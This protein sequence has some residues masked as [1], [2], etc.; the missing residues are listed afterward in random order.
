MKRDAH[1]STQGIVTPLS[2]TASMIPAQPARLGRQK[3]AQRLPHLRGEHAPRR[4][5]LAAAGCAVS[6]PPRRHVSLTSGIP[7]H[8]T[9]C[10]LRGLLA[11]HGADNRRPVA[12]VLRVVGRVDV[13]V[14]VGGW[15]SEGHIPLHAAGPDAP[16]TASLSSR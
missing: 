15:L 8:D 7:W 3:P 14:G 11:D 12:V 13:R 9:E 6:E 4:P 10:D 5:R 16:D 2:A 1:P